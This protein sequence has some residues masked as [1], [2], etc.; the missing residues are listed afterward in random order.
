MSDDT[1]T[2][3]PRKNGRTAII[4]GAARG[5]GREIALRLARQGFRLILNHHHRD[6]DGAEA[7]CRACRVFQ[8]DVQSVKADIS[9][10]DEVARLFR[11]AREAYGSVDVLVN[12]AG[13]NIDKPL[14]QMAETDWD[15][16]VDTN[17]KGV[18]L[19]C[20]AVAPIMIGQ[21]Q[22][23][24]IL[25]LG[26]STAI[27][28]RRNGLNYCASKA[29]VLAMTKCLALELAPKVRVNCIIPGLIETE[30]ARARFR[31]DDAGERRGRE[32]GIPL[33]FIGSAEDIAGAAAFLVSQDAR[34]ITGQKL[35]VDGG[36]Y[37]Y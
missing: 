17:M 34:Y 9:R 21:P 8:A 29:G 32:L 2:D 10:S 20:R 25:N 37:M 6:D 30:E 22:G 16:V 35:I 11:I 27:S 31:L 1:G 12:N 14:L 3:S 13:L 26:A 36:Q 18:F 33:G 5:I 19:C 23:G 24:V 4:T 28:G 15:S 7:A